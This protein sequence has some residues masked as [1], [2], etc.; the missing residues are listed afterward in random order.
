[1]NGRR[2]V[3]RERI[4]GSPDLLADKKPTFSQD[5]KYHCNAFSG[6]PTNYLLHTAFIVLEFSLL[7]RLLQ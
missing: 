5:L 6:I 4:P 3:K 7:E 2:I 1:M